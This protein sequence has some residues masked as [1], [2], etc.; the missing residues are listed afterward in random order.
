MAEIIDKGTALKVIRDKD[1]ITYY[2]K[3]DGSGNPILFAKVF[4]G[5]FQ[6]FNDS[7]VFE[8]F[9]F[10]ENDDEELIAVTNPNCESFDDLL[11]KVI[12]FLSETTVEVGIE[13]FFLSATGDFGTGGGWAD[14][15]FI[16]LVPVLRFASNFT[17]R[18]IYMFFGLTRITFPE[19]DPQVGFIV[20]SVGQPNVNDAVRWKLSCSYIAETESLAEPPA[21]IIFQ[22]QVLT[23][24][25]ADSRQA[26]LVFTVDRTLIANQDV[27]QFN[28]ERVGG[29][30]ADTYGDDIAV[31]QSGIIVQTTNHNP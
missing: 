20:Y 24:L 17:E 11:D 2:D 7:Q 1:N 12:I 13:D 25:V 8:T 22:T 6:L 5:K 21:Q 30:A 19:V 29:D 23:T 3:L 14:P 27:M 26:I 9:H 15:G 16:S 4:D 18:A 10:A 31:G 28:L